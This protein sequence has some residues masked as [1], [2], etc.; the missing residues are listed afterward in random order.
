MIW[1]PIVFSLHP[2][3]LPLSNSSPADE[4]NHMWQMN[5]WH[6]I[7]I[8]ER[9]FDFFWF[10]VFLKAYLV[11]QIKINLILL[12]KK[13]WKNWTFLLKKISMGQCQLSS[14]GW[15]RSSGTD[16]LE[17]DDIFQKF[18]CRRW[19]TH[20]EQT[21]YNLCGLIWSPFSVV[22]YHPH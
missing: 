22:D 12:E 17:Q 9:Q 2:K 7:F 10:F 21:I 3:N 11:F 6:M 4:L 13:N 19:N 15:L 18:I 16:N 14:N 1:K 5:L 8:H 20:L